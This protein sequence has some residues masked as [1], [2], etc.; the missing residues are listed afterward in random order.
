[1]EIANDSLRDF[2]YNVF[3]RSICSARNR[4][5][6]AG[7][8]LKSSKYAG[9]FYAILAAFFFSSMSALVHL[10][11]DLP[12]MQKAL[13]RNLPALL[14]AALALRRNGIPLRVEKANRGALAGRCIAGTIGLMGNF[15]AID[16]M[17]L[18][19]ANMLNKLSPFFAILFSFLIL[20]EKLRLPQI[21]GVAAAFAGA[22]L[23]IRPSG[24]GADPLAALAGVVG[25]LGAGL[26]YTFVR[27][28]GQQH[29]P[30]Q[31]IV[32]YFSLTSCL[33]TAPFFLLN[34]Q[35]MS[36]AQL[37][38]MLAA[39]CC[40]AGGQFSIT[41]AYFHAPARELSVYE[42]TQILFAALWGFM[43]FGQVPDGWSVLGYAII[44]GSAVVMFLYNNQLGPFRGKARA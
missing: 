35:P 30:S 23:I 36:P 21:A 8:F 1:M 10:A 34:A 11:G 16:R 17:L 32:F 9:L 27:R 13:F 19:D 20:K 7:V 26:A 28:L 6:E 14:I 22:L 40:G 39:G 2:F 4:F 24:A 12:S 37:I 44:I 42:Y 25:G 15:Y 29:Q 38:C 5:L 41:K 33:A 43:L 31:Q 3:K 18:S